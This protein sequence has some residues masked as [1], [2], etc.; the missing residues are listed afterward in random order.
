MANKGN[1]RSGGHWAP[2]IA[3]YFLAKSAALTRR[4][5]ERSI[6]I[7]HLG[8]FSGVFDFLVQGEYYPTFAVSNTYDIEAY[9]SSVADAAIDAFERPG[10]C[11]EQAAA[12]QNAAITLDPENTGAVETVQGLCAVATMT[13]WFEVYGPFE[14]ISGL[15]P[16]DI[17][18]TSST[19]FPEP[20][21]NGFLNREEVQMKLGVNIAAGKG[22]NYTNSNGNIFNREFLSRPSL[23]KRE[24]YMWRA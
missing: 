23:W 19:Q 18:Q 10:G 5:S 4:S 22:V 11:G 14:E 6:S 20:Y 16:F 24:I 9:P 13:C 7:S 15:N 17:T 12:C 21:A 8:I 3:T 1:P 2:G